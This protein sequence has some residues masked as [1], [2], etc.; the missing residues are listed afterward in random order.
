MPTLLSLSGEN[1]MQ[2]LSPEMK[3]VNYVLWGS[4]LLG[5]VEID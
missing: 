4:V 3:I 2:K 5:T 1:L